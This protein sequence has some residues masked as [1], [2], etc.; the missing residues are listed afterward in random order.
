MDQ[1]LEVSYFSQG[2]SNMSFPTKQFERM[3]Y[4]G[5]IK[6][7]PNPVLEW[8]LS[9]C[10]KIEDPNENIKIHKGQSNRNGKRVDGIIASIMALGGSLSMK[11]EVSKYSK[12]LSPDDIII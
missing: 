7:E 6:F 12:P 2:I 3:L 9:G 8:M 4:E 1:G 5:T 11:E 10:I